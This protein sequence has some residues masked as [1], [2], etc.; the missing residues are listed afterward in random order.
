MG[1]LIIL[2]ICPYLCPY[3]YETEFCE[4]GFIFQDL[5][6]QQP[7]PRKRQLYNKKVD[8]ET[9]DDPIE[10]KKDPIIVKEIKEVKEN[11]EEVKEEPK[12]EPKEEVKE[13]EENDLIVEVE[14]DESIY[15][16]IAESKG[17]LP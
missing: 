17:K 8:L 15:V 10:N 3:F 5:E 1:N 4:A 14:T 13:E 11:K 9:K 16:Y 12:E 7:P 2:H 6:K